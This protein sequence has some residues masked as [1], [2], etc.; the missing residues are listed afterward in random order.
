[1]DDGFGVEVVQDDVVVADGYGGA[2]VVEE[3]AVVVDD[4]FGLEGEEN[5]EVDQEV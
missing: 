5:L 2:E 4:G 1:V 3:E